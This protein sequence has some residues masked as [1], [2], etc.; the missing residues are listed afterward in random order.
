MGVIINAYVAIPLMER[1]AEDFEQVR[2]LEELFMKYKLYKEKIA[3]ME[4][5]IKSMQDELSASDA[6]D[7]Q[8]EI[9][10]TRMHYDAVIREIEMLRLESSNCTDVSDLRNAFLKI[11]DL[12][13]LKKKSTDLL[14]ELVEHDVI[15]ISGELADNEHMEDGKKCM[16][17]LSKDVEEV[18]LITG[19]HHEI[20]AVCREILKSF[21][22]KYAREVLPAEMSVFESDEKLYFV[23]GNMHGVVNGADSMPELLFNAKQKSIREMERFK[24]IFNVAIGCLKE[25]LRAMVIQRMLS[26]D[27]VRLNSSIFEGTDAY[28]QNCSEWRLDIVMREIIDIARLKLGEDVVEVEEVNERL[29]RHVSLRYRRFVDCFEMFRSSGSKRHGKGAKV[30]DRAIMKMFDV[31]CDS[32]PIQ[33]RFCEFADMSHF[34]RKYPGHCLYEELTKR[35]EEVFFWIIRDASRVDISLGDPVMSVKMYLRE[36]HVDFMENVSMFVPKINKCLFE[37]QFFETLN[38]CM[39][40]KITE[41]GSVSGRTRRSLAELIEYVLDFSFHLPTGMV[42]N[43]EKLK[44]YGLA[45]SLGKEELLRQYEQGSVRISEEELDRLCSLY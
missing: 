24:E 23:C 39:M 18:F 19:K 4:E 3:E 26:D 43:R 30:V 31:K 13:V 22:C 32:K 21:F 29:P 33:Q 11:T 10:E 14:K 25:N 17:V 15:S 38:L 12:E 27:E 45:V 44:M 35:K 9:D 40:T 2:C 5:E 7:I 6:Q 1:I 20:R 41:L 42:G 34:V 16:V 8:N 28:V 37:I 36:K